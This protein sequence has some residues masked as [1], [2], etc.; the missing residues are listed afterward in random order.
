MFPRSGFKIGRVFGIDI[1][2]HGT[3]L[4]IFVLVVFS[5]SEELRLRQ[6][7]REW[8]KIPGGI[9]PWAV[10]LLCSVIFFACLLLHEMSHSYVAKRSGLAIKKIT[11]FI[12]GGIAEMSR[13]VDSPGL[14]FKMAIAGPAVNFVLFGFFYLF[15]RIAL[16][17]EAGVV[18]LAPLWL[19]WV[20]NLV[21]GVFNLLPGFP[22]DGGRVLRSIIWKLTGDM[23][24]ATRVASIC[25]QICGAGMITVGLFFFFRS[26]MYEIGW[27][28][29]VLIGF[30]LFQLAR[31]SYKQT[32]VRLS[33]ADTTVGDIMH[34]EVPLVEASTPLTAL[35]NNYFGVYH[36]P[37]L[38]VVE[39]GRLV[40]VVS[41]D[42]L[43]RV[44]P[45]EWDVLN[46]GRIA[47]PLT[48]EE[49]VSPDTPLETAMLPL[50]RGRQ[51]ALLVVQ[52]G[53]IVG[54]L[55][56]ESL[57]RYMDMRMKLNRR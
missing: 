10:G 45:A 15:F 4:I 3:W 21:I 25:G 34:T 17:A 14:E 57:I 1:V 40:G 51:F 6:W 30:F 48:R 13:D 20:L 16:Y 31:S 12:F 56:R 29:F 55:T 19:L 11:L 28:W 2:I 9:V 47:R 53:R 46:A 8:G 41:N 38:P 37:I 52:E 27:L 49:T 26:Q 32:L 39:E 54:L 33:T 35:R 50:M 43:S 23:R 18:L 36:L 24:L 5:L 44:F 7:P 22:L 42:Q